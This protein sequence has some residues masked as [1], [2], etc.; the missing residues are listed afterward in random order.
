MLS[1][2]TILRCFKTDKMAENL[3]IKELSDNTFSV[4]SLHNKLRTANKGRP[5]LLLSTVKTQHK[6]K[7]EI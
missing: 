3:I 6:T 4:H 7:A 2:Y 1:P 5:T